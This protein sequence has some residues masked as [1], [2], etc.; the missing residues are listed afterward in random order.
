MMRDEELE[1][2]LTCDI[3]KRCR[4]FMLWMEII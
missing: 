4:G 3:L 1:A 2:R